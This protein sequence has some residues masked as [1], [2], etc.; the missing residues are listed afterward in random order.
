MTDTNRT[1]PAPES[2][3]EAAV[4]KADQLAWEAPAL[5]PVFT[6]DTGTE[7]WYSDCPT[8]CTHV[9][10][11]HPAS[12][13]TR[14]HRGDELCIRLDLAWPFYTRTP[15]DGV[16]AGHLTAHL[17]RADRS[18]FTGIRLGLRQG[19]PSGD[20]TS[21]QFLP[22]MGRDE[23]LELIAVLQHLLKVGTTD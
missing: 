4:T 10:E 8:W 21:T 15:E 7:A 11:G 14:R 20:V 19:D 22:A 9:D 16:K 1:T 17:E 18:G 6:P 13:R 23:A 3:S 2:A 5:R 12:H